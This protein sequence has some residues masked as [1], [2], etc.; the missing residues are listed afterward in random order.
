MYI[1][2]YMILC[3]YV[4]MHMHVG[5]SLLHGCVE[6]LAIINV[7]LSSIQQK[8]VWQVAN[9]GNCGVFCWSRNSKWWTSGW[10]RHEN[11]LSLKKGLKC[12]I[13]SEEYPIGVGMFH[14]WIRLV[15][16]I[17]IHKWN[18]LSM[19]RHEV[20]PWQIAGRHLGVWQMATV[21]QMPF[22]NRIV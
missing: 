8:N 11:T 12:R 13:L 20:S 17:N 5:L 2:I 6:I 18:R 15:D 1:H 4:C 21:N 9:H 3:V 19:A 7:A 16:P 14:Q 10:S 22:L